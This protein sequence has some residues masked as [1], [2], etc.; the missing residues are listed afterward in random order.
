MLWIFAQYGLP[1]ATNAYLFNGDVADRGDH[2]CE[3]F[4]LIFGYMLVE[5]GSI[6]LTLDP[7]PRP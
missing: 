2:A 4:A 1:S 6:T 5:P 3:I 7:S